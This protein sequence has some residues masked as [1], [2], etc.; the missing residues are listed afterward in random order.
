MTDMSSTGTSSSGFGTRAITAMF[1]SRD[2]ADSAV[3]S[4]L[5]N[6]FRQDDVRLVPGYEKDVAGARHDDTGGFWSSL[7]DFFFPEEDRH[8][9]AEG[10]S[11]GH[12]LVSVNTMEA[13]HDRALDILDDEG[14]IDMDERE[15]EWRSQGWTGYAGAPAT[16]TGTSTGA[17]LGAGNDVTR[18]SVAGSG[19]SGMNDGSRLG[20]STGAFGGSSGDALD[21]TDDE[22]PR[23]LGT[24]GVSGDGL[25]LTRGPGA[26]AAASDRGTVGGLEGGFV[27]SD[28]AG[29]SATTA[30]AGL[31]GEGRFERG[32]DV[33][34]S[35]T[36]EEVIPLAEE[37]L[38]VG[39]REVEGGR[40]RVRSYVVERPV[41]E[42]VMLRREHVGVQ[43]HVVDRA[44]GTGED[45]FRERTVELDERREEPVVSKETRIREEVSLRKDVQDE[46]RTV[47]DTVR[48]T[49]VEVED[50]RSEGQQDQRRR[51]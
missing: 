24:V 16:G 26:N 43:R 1:S 25:G 45:P 11:R 38:R 31:S 39:K 5:E 17:G 10:L 28:R 46:Q 33:A 7:S 48:R 8:S 49:E 15:D 36:D 50:E 42:Q 29:Q 32:G 37:N 41:E 27:G 34:R 2:A 23:P 19:T 3:K 51:S 21:R 22:A 47:S 30:G 40:V 18:S 35:G 12:F 20:G 9:Y 13:N 6:G 4:L 14:T 44:V